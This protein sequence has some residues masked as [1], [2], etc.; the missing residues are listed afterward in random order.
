MIKEINKILGLKDT[1]KAP[2]KLMEILQN[3]KERERIFK[4]MLVL[5]NHKLD[6]DWFEQ[7]FQENFADSKGG[8]VLTHRH[9]ANLMALLLLEDN[10]DGV[11]RDPCAGTGILTIAKWDQAKKK[12]NFKPSDYFFVCEE[13]D[14]RAI[15]FL[16]FNLTVRGMNAI[17]IHCDTMTRESW[18]AFY[19]HNK[20]D[21]PNGFS[22][23][24][25]LPYTQQTKASLMITF[26][27][28]YP[29]QIEF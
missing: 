23:I 19:L 8:Q 27:N 26:T 3:R 6:F 22:I 9:I 1:S 4:K 24:N 12:N 7:Y 28:H 18:G 21:D 25:R 2:S 20:K 15:P 14:E 13:L 11:T 17:V 16:L 5:F 29:E 10:G